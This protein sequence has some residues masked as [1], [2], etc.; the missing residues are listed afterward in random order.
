MPEKFGNFSSRWPDGMLIGAKIA[1]QSQ[2]WQKKSAIG[3]GTKRAST[4]AESI[5][6]N[7]PATGDSDGKDRRRRHENGQ[8]KR[9]QVC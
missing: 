5:F 3:G 1:A 9:S 6:N 8:G 4:E 7:H 2:A